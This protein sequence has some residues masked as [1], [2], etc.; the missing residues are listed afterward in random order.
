MKCSCDSVS[1]WGKVAHT[2]KVFLFCLT[3]GDDTVN[4]EASQWAGDSSHFK[5]LVA[6]ASSELDQQKNLKRKV[7]DRETPPPQLHMEQTSNMSDSSD[8]DSAPSKAKWERSSS[9]TSEESGGMI[10]SG[11][12]SERKSV[13]HRLSRSTL[14]KNRSSCKKEVKPKLSPANIKLEKST[15]SKSSQQAVLSVKADG[16]DTNQSPSRGSKGRHPAA[17][18]NSSNSPAVQQPEDRRESSKGSESTKGSKGPPK[19]E[20]QRSD[21]KD[22]SKSQ[23]KK[24]VSRQGDNRV[25][26]RS[27]RGSTSSLRKAE[28][29]EARLDKH[30]RERRGASSA[31]HDPPPSLSPAVQTQ[32]EGQRESSD[33]QTLS[34]WNKKQDGKGETKGKGARPL[35]H[36][37]QP[38]H[39]DDSKQQRKDVAKV[40]E[41]QRKSSHSP[42]PDKSGIKQEHS[43]SSSKHTSPSSHKDASHQRSASPKPESKAKNGEVKKSSSDSQRVSPAVKQE[44]SRSPSTSPRPEQ[45]ISSS[46]TPSVKG[47]I[48]PTSAKETSASSLKAS[49]VREVKDNKPSVKSDKGSKEVTLTG[50]HASKA[51]VQKQHSHGKSSTGSRDV[52]PATKHLS[53]T[54]SPS[55]KSEHKKSGEHKKSS[56]GHGNPSPTPQKDSSR[57]PST[58]PRPENRRR[59]HSSK[60]KTSTPSTSPRPDSREGQLKK[61]A[62]SK[63]RDKQSPSPKPDSRSQDHSKGASSKDRRTPSHSP[64]PNHGTHKQ[65]QHEQGSHGQRSHA[66]GSHGHGQ[67]TVGGSKDGRTPSTSPKPSSR[68][69]R[70]S[71]SS[72]SSKEKLHSASSSDKME[73]RPSKEEKQA[74]TPSV[75]PKPDSRHRDKRTSSGSPAPPKD[76]SHSSSVS[77]KEKS[78]NEQSSSQKN[79]GVPKR[80]SSSDKSKSSS[81]SIRNSSSSSKKASKTSPSSPKPDKLSSGGERKKGSSGVDASRDS[82]T[83]QSSS[84]VRADRDDKGERSQRSSGTSPS[85]KADPTENGPNSQRE[86]LQG[87]HNTGTSRSSRDRPAFAQQVSLGF[88]EEDK[89]ANIDLVAGEN[90]VSVSGQGLGEG[91][92]GLDG[93]QIFSAS[94]SLSGTQEVKA[95]DS[96]VSR[97]RTTSHKEPHRTPAAGSHSRTPSP[98]SVKG[99]T[100]H[101]SSKSS[102]TP[103]NHGVSGPADTSQHQSPVD[104][105]PV[106]T[107]TDH[108][109][110]TTPS[111]ETGGGYVVAA[112][113]AG[114]PS[115]K[116]QASHS[117][118]SRRENS[119]PTK[120]VTVT[121]ED[122]APSLRQDGRSMVDG[123]GKATETPPTESDPARKTPTPPLSPTLW[124]G[125]R[126]PPGSPVP[127]QASGRGGRR[128]SRMSSTS[129]SSSCSSSLSSSSSR[130]RSSSSTR[131]S[132]PKHHKSPRRNRPSNARRRSLRS[133]SAS[134]STTTTTTSSSED[135]GDVDVKQGVMDSAL[136]AN[137]PPT[138]CPP[139][140][141]PLFGSTM[142]SDKTVK[143][144]RGEMALP[145]PASP[146]SS[147]GSS[148]SPLFAAAATPESKARKDEVVMRQYSLGSA[149]S[150]LSTSGMSEVLMREYSPGSSISSLST[151]GASGSPLFGSLKD[152]EKDQDVG[153]KEVM[154]RCS[155]SSSTPNSSGSLPDVDW[156]THSAASRNTK[157]CG[158]SDKAADA[159]SSKGG[160]KGERQ[161]KTAGYP[162]KGHLSM[163]RI[164]S[165]N[166][167]PLT[168]PDLTK[169]PPALYCGLSGYPSSLNNGYPS[170]PVPPAPRPGYLPVGSPPSPVV[171]VAPGYVSHSPSTQAHS[172]H[173]GPAKHTQYRNNNNNNIGPWAAGGISSPP[174]PPPSPSYSN[175][176]HLSPNS[177]GLSGPPYYPSPGSVPVHQPLLYPATQGYWP[178]SYKYQPSSRSG[179]EGRTNGPPRL[180]SPGSGGGGGGGGHPHSWPS[181]SVGGGP[182]LSSRAMRRQ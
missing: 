98:A 171:T 28:G 147:L 6:L 104:T 25:G 41:S 39:K 44:A 49:A 78:G 2:D 97:S 89:E 126:T 125:P 101:S 86:N 149:T 31:G 175:P 155:S 151:S 167:T 27:L 91:V 121:L 40:K 133:Y 53:R 73:K 181:Y 170:P 50:S 109:S 139:S 70:Q 180:Y 135:E 45:R 141:S 1:R 24:P 29:R 42:K 111:R 8:S 108:V 20:V 64:K 4:P 169:P 102:P 164:S 162:S 106:L 94:T 140:V 142:G 61:S 156:P 130:G 145:S 13:S 117:P 26:S 12:L 85:R 120:T 154:L 72:T 137:T 15:Q 148:T 176:P 46:K 123:A 132:A 161:T 66:Q 144:E 34:S 172:K 119:S 163:T 174:P 105:E 32:R 43:P 129:S 54:P 92:G 55:T 87:D 9:T 128:T 168:L 19:F 99:G 67:T 60:D 35:S 93:G 80:E 16:Q 83:E 36:S 88:S 59:E 84:Q 14:R 95:G 159:A 146:G 82:K 74:Q 52:S 114:Q 103:C 138:P 11:W 182:P 57:T 165:R 37:P 107:S 96:R 113:R 69:N 56:S 79:H 166:V 10:P 112:E 115:G 65:G 157:T 38:A 160:D 47:A 110:A 122:I 90:S 75:S 30:Q 152:A 68:S 77:P 58:S 124:R 62:G 33:K 76:A 17:S 71:G 5:A 23:T 81:S 177:P 118:V 116:V 21:E 18:S 63:E 150:S 3:D 131:S 127:W 100:D 178:G 51:D 158:D 7:D 136:A 153:R 143:E 134:S 173:G 48:S 179:V 22:S